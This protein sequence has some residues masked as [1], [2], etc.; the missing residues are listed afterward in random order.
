MDQKFVE[1]IHK[2]TSYKQRSCSIP[3][4]DPKNIKQFLML[5]GFWLGFNFARFGVV[6]HLILETEANWLE[7]SKDRMDQD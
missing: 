5:H 1:S 6:R 7:Y 4:H 2:I 3:E